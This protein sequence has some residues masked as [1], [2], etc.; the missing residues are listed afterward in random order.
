MS[1]IPRARPSD[2]LAALSTVDAL[3]DTIGWAIKDIFHDVIYRWIKLNTGKDQRRIIEN[4]LLSPSVPATL[5]VSIPKQPLE[6]PPQ[7]YSLYYND[8]AGRNIMFDWSADDQDS[9][10]TLLGEVSFGPTFMA[11]KAPE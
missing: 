2:C 11:C 9:A 1:A 3:N 6:N 4:V 5:P 8:I 7:Q 10:L